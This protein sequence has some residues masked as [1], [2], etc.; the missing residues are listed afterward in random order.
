MPVKY[1]DIVLP[2]PLPRLFTYDIPEEFHETLQKGMRVVVPF[3][4]KK[5]LSGIVFDIHCN[6]PE[7]YDTKPILAILDNKPLVTSQQLLLWQ[8]ISTYYQCSLGEVYKAA[9]P[10]GLKL[11][12]ETRFY[13]NDEFEA[14]TDLSEKALLVLDFL[15]H[16]K[17]CTISDL[18]KITGLKNSYPILKDLI[19]QQAVYVDELVAEKY[20]PKEDLFISLHI[21]KRSEEALRVVFDKLEKAPKQLQLLM[22]FIQKSGG[23]TQSL[24]GNK[25]LR[26]EVLEEPGNTSAPLNE[27][28]KKN[29][30]I[31][32]SIEVD[33]LDFSQIPTIN[34]KDLSKE[35]HKALSDIREG[36]ISRKPVLLHGV[37]SSGKTELYIHL[38]D[39]I[40]KQGKQALYLLPEIA[41][42]TQ[43]TSRLRAHF[44]NKLGI[45]HSKFSDEERVEVWN[46]LLNKKN[47]QVIVGVR[48][49]V[50]LPFSELG[51]VIVDEEHENSFKQYDPAPRYHARDVALVLAKS[52]NAQVLLGTATPSIESYYN[53]KSGKYHLVELQTRF[54]GILLPDIRVVNTR[55]AYRKKSMQSHFS[56]EL[57]ELMGKALNNKEQIILFQN[58][59]GFAPYLE[60]AKCGWIPTCSH[61]DVS[62]TY[63][64]NIDQ[65]V[66]HYCGHSVTTYKICQACESPSLFTKGFGTQK[67]EEEIQV[68]FPQAGVVRMDHD[69]TRSKIGYEKIITSF[70]QGKFDILVGTQMVTKG[71]DFDRVSLVGILNADNMLNNPDFRAFERSFQMIAQVSGRAGRK[72]RQGTVI[73]QT[74]NPEHPVIQQVKTNDYES[75]FNQQIV[76]RKEFKYPPFYRLIFLTIKHKN[77][78]ISNKAANELAQKLRSVFGSRIIGPQVPPITKIQDFHLQRIL[79]KLEK[80]SSAVK[81][82]ELM[83]DCINQILSQD[84]WRY[85]SIVADVD[86]Y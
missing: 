5:Q 61:C 37:T 43:I 65:L 71:L 82:K 56:P 21:E 55:E 46:D 42:T 74:S 16:E 54:E 40:I 58:R 29:I 77:Q 30:L 78:N 47:Y 26:K 41:L 81:A 64:K 24:A 28:I 6:K 27:L 52:F 70:E 79:I 31:Q 38:I 83:Q 36:F 23:V 48:S 53:A 18:N 60:C 66:C 68:I 45:Y 1:A 50:F 67:I 2:V 17:Q 51:L 9:L 32:E 34:K 22:T 12:S 4:K 85:V 3:G 15:T 76:E 73:L 69:T 49:S 11:E 35:Q 10:S 57:I 86:P 39:D 13:Y 80:N 62:M 84:P 72:N 59:R 33:R 44:G 20:K 75:F 14:T 63:H 7:A 25:I 19:E 8:W